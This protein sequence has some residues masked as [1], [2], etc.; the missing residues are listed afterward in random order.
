SGAYC[1]SAQHEFTRRPP[2][3]S[4]EG[5][6]QPPLTRVPASTVIVLLGK[7]KKVPRPKGGKSNGAIG[8]VLAMNGFCDSA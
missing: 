7:Q 2:T 4:G 5:T 6:A 8:V 3:A 1:P